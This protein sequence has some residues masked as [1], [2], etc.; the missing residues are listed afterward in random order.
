MAKI[1]DT[2]PCVICDDPAILKMVRPRRCSGGS[3]WWR[4]ARPDS[5]LAGMGVQRVRACAGL[6][7]SA[8][9]VGS[10]RAR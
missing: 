7:R 4:D 10:V 6:Q 1:G 5:I 3:S 8:G 2:K 9:R